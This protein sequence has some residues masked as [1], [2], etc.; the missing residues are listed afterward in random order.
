MTCGFI[1]YILIQKYGPNYKLDF[2][3]IRIWAIIIT[4]VLTIL[5]LL[6]SFIP[7]IY[8]VIWFNNNTNLT[9][10]ITYR[11]LDVITANLALLAS[12]LLITKNKEAFTIF[13]LCNVVFIGLLASSSL[14]LS[15][16]QIFVYLVSN[17]FAMF[18]WHYKSKYQNLNI[19]EN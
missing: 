4:I 2:K 9:G 17:I 7:P 16:I 18:A 14:W 10:D 15:A 11:V 3:L 19:E 8:E 13:I 5:G 12:V 1:R 6:L